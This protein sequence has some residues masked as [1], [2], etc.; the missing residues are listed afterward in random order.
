[1]KNKKVGMDRGGMLNVPFWK[2]RFFKWGTTLATGPMDCT[3]I[4]I[5][6]S[7]KNRFLK[8]SENLTSKRLHKR[9]RRN[10]TIFLIITK[11]K[12]SKPV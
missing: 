10:G 11:K 1:M 9:H 12:L 4:I 8:I 3:G 2:I 7:S 6:N 5:V